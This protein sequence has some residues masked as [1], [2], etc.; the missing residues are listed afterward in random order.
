MVTEVQGDHR[1]YAK[2][3]Q[4]TAET[5]TVLVEKPFA[6]S[7]EEGAELAELARER[8][9]HLVAAPFVHLAPT[10]R[11]LWTEITDGVI[12]RVHSARGVVAAETTASATRVVAAARTAA[13][14]RTAM[15]V[16]ST[17]EPADLRLE[18]DEVS[19][20]HVHDHTRSPKEQR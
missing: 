2:A 8:D 7:L 15:P 5:R 12:G 17:F 4:N 10:F 19:P 18:K 16:T 9:L 13:S 20:G 6:G 1:F 3:T 11:A 14:Q